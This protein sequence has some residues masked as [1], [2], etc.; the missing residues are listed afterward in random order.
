MIKNIL[1]TGGAGFIGSN[2]A[3]YFQDNYPSYKITIF[4][5]FDDGSKL[6]NGNN[7]FLGNFQNINFFRGKLIC[8]D[9]CNNSDLELLNEKYDIIFHL[10]AIS[11]TRVEEQ[12]LIIKNNVNS[13]YFF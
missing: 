6:R 3:R 10:A 7:K 2:L 8:G 9:I 12:Q 11:D 1:I 5:I 13:F 4:D